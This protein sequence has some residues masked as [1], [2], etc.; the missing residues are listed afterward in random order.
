MN[1]LVGWLITLL[2]L[3]HTDV[4]QPFTPL[5]P[6]TLGSALLDS[7]EFITLSTCCTT[8]DLTSNLT[9][10]AGDVCGLMSL[11]LA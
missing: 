5:A 4:L 2:T 6:G 8:S 10:T 7:A 9:G 1:W 3:L 11:T